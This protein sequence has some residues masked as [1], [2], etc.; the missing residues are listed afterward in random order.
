MRI[1][2]LSKWRN[3]IPALIA[4][5]LA[6]CSVSPPSAIS[7]GA[8][9]A[10]DAAPAAQ[11][12]DA[13]ASKPKVALLLPLSARG[14]AAIIADSLKKSA[15]LAL[16]SPGGARIELLILDD[17]GTADGARTAAQAAIAGGA[18]L[19]IGPLFSKSV[20]A[21]AVM[22]RPAGLPIV[23][24]SNDEQVAGN[25]VYLVSFLDHPEIDRIV[26]YAAS[27]GRRRFAALVSDDATG[28][29]SEAHF[30]AAVLRNGGSVRAVESHGSSTTSKLEAIR[31]L[32]PKLNWSDSDGDR[33]DALFL[34]GAE[35]TLASLGP[36]LKQADLDPARV[37]IIG[38]GGFDY[39]N[40]GRDP[41]FAGAWFPDADPGAPRAFTDAFVRAYGHA[42]PRIAGLAFDAVTL[43]KALAGGPD[44]GRYAPSQLTRSQGFETSS[45][46]L[47]LLP[48]GT[49]AHALAILEV[50]SYGTRVIDP[51]TGSAGASQVS[52]RSS[53]QQ[54]ARRIN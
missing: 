2:R 27:Q 25:G 24:F 19:M 17:R 15:E 8:I 33:V 3:L 6:A 23:A 5:T 35:D 20:S 16:Q 11:A 45:G 18:E 4:M 34:P 37:K 38:T 46:T 13:R 43:A 52:E 47:K 42:P 32:R 49:S 44:R 9:P 30:R 36:L 28:R 12:G 40:V 7:T 48:D 51:P 41:V 53:R 54:A 31:R 10:A 50:Q 29:R 1:L 26:D 14:H 21:A 22:A 39:P